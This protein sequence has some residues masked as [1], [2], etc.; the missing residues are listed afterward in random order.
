[1]QK[2]C[3]IKEFINISSISRQLDAIDGIKTQMNYEISLPI[4]MYPAPQC[5]IIY[6][7]HPILNPFQKIKNSNKY[8]LAEY[9]IKSV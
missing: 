7:L 2:L 9:L 4:T 8:R 3:T 6:M 1:M 5:E